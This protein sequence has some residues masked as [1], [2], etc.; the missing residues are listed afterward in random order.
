VQAHSFVLLCAD[1]NDPPLVVILGYSLLCSSLQDIRYKSTYSYVVSLKSLAASFNNRAGIQ[2][3]LQFLL[4]LLTGWGIGAAAMKAAIS[5]R[6]LLV[7]EATL[8]NAVNRSAASLTASTVFLSD[9]RRSFQ[10]S[11]NPEQLYKVEVFQGV[12]LDAGLVLD[13]TSQLYSLTLLPSVPQLYL[14]FS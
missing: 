4:G 13:S 11:V 2:L 1:E 8:Q 5:V 3:V 9:L 6:S 14:V 10:G 12:F 7:D